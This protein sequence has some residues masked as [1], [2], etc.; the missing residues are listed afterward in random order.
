[1][2]Y[3]RKYKSRLQKLDK[4]YTGAG[5]WFAFPVSKEHGCLHRIPKRYAKRRDY[6]I[7]VK[8]TARKT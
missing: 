7:D 1:L 2:E 3:L 5:S 8:L 4:L 6:N